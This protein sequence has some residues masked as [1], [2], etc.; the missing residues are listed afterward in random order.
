MKLQV[1][2]RIGL[3]GDPEPRSFMLGAHRLTVEQIIDRWLSSDHGHFK[4]QASD[5]CIYILR[6]DN[7]SDEWELTLFQSTTT[8]APVGSGLPATEC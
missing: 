7:P 8:T 4:V 2:I 3:H 1:E 6:R 5:H